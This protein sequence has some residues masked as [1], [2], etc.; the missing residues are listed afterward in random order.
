MAHEVWLVAAGDRTEGAPTAGITREEAVAT[1]GM[2]AGLARTEAGMVSG[3]H[4]H[5][6]YQSAIYVVSGAMRMEFGS[7]GAESV[8][9]GPGDFI[10]V[11][12]HAVHR[13]SNP[14]DE[15][16]RFIVVRAGS[17]DPVFNVDGPA[18]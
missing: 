6:D 9:A 16:S 15:E 5:G 3:W 2:W 7:G 13:E 11:A 12:A 4:H 17:G 1:E 14:T 10:Y 18:H 8:E